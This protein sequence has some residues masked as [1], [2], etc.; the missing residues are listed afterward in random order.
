MFGRGRARKARSATIMILAR[1]I[2]CRL[3]FEARNLDD[4]VSHAL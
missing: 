3:A 2:V 4:P 1:L